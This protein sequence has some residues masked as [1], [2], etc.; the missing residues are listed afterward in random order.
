M[1]YTIDGDFAI[2]HVDLP[3]IAVVDMQ[4]DKDVIEDTQIDIYA[5]SQR[6]QK[7]IPLNGPNSTSYRDWKLYNLIYKKYSAYFIAQTLDYNERR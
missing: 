4:V 2:R 5:W 3:I 1:T 7:L 6:R